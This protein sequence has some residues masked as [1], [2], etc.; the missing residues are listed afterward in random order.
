MPSKIDL[1]GQ[2]FGRL[3]VLEDTQKRTG[4]GEVIWRCKCDCGNETE[5]RGGHL[6]TKNVQFFPHPSCV[7]H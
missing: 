5:V 4:K 7:T 1:T 2:R 6:R 3:L